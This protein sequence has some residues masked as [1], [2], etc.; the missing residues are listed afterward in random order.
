MKFELPDIVDGE[1][2]TSRRPTSMGAYSTADTSTH[3]LIEEW[4][5]LANASV[6]ARIVQADLAAIS[7]RSRHISAHLGTIS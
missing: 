6:A 3:S 7:A 2:P 1:D 5:V 4:M